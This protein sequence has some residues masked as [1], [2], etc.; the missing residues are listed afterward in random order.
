MKKHIAFKEMKRR[1]YTRSG[2]RTSGKY[3]TGLV[4]N[5]YRLHQKAVFTAQC[6]ASLMR[7]HFQDPKKVKWVP[8]GRWII[9]TRANGTKLIFTDFVC[10]FD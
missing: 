2:T 8:D 5:R 1:K 7:H 6:L 9:E 10:S 3:K 4:S